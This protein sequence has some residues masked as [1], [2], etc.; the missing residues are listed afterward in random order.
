MHITGNVLRNCK[1]SPDWCGPCKPKGHQFHSQSGH[2][3]GLQARSLVGG[4]GEALDFVSFS[5][6]SPLSEGK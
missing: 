2:M 1:G 3:P 4:L 6:P 5:L